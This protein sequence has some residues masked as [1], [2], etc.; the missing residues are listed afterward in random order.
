MKPHALAHKGLLLMLTALATLSF[1]AAALAQ[2]TVPPSLLQNSR[3]SQG[4]QIRFCVDDSTPGAAFNREVSQA[5]AD[6]L[7]VNAQFVAGPEGSSFPLDGLGF[8]DEL[9]LVMSELCDVFVGVSILPEGS[10]AYPEWA[11]VT[12]PFAEIPFV[13]VVKDPNYSALKDIPPGVRLGTTMGSLGQL[14]LINYIG[15]QPQD[16][17]WV[18]LPYGDPKLM[19][20][21]LE[22]GTLAG[23]AIYLPSLLELTNND[24]AALGLRIVPFDP[25][26]EPKSA[27]GFLVSGR[28][29]Y[30]RSQLDEAIASLVADGSIERLKQKYGYSR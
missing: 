14:V 7:L 30:L 10:T 13:F 19:L 4:D 24:P 2:N 18:M 22:D 9:Q 3:P 25:I 17:R 21:R 16:R 20:K 5:V 27:S 11:T 23:A 26:A 8:L 29:D 6:A 1:D 15:Q 28:D 12:R